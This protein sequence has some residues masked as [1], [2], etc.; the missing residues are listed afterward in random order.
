M[1]SNSSGSAATAAAT[2][3]RSLTSRVQRENLGAEFGREVLDPIRAAGGHDDARP[4]G[5]EPA[6]HRGA[7]AA[8]RPGDENGARLD[9]CSP[10]A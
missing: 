2:A 5:G 10:I 7:E 8:A 3:A 4:V 1:A 9:A 6:G